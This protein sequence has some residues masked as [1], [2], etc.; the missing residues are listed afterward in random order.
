MKLRVQVHMSCPVTSPAGK[1]KIINGTKGLLPAAQMQCS[2]ELEHVIYC[3]ASLGF[4][5]LRQVLM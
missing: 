1:L 4:V 5:F 2:V 3:L